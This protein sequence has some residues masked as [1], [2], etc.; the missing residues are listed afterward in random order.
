MQR[1]TKRIVGAIALIAALAAGGAAFTASNTLPSTDTAGYGNISVTGADVSDISNT[2]SADGQDITE[3]TLTFAS[4]IPANATVE[5]GFGTTGGTA[6]TTLPITCTVAGNQLSATCG[7][8]TSTLSTT[9]NA[10]EFAVAVV[11]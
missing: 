6:P 9:A 10:G 8:G 1:R 4:A 11:H 2:L 3:V 7:D 5:A